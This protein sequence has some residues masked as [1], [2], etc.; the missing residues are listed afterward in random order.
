[1]SRNNNTVKMA[2]NWSQ[3]THK[4]Q[5]QVQV[6]VSKIYFY[7]YAYISTILNNYTE[8]IIQSL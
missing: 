6:Y 8:F 5:Q 4:N 7:I 3:V 1:M 2:M